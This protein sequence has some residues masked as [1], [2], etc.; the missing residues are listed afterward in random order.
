VTSSVDAPLVLDSSNAPHYRW[1]ADC[2]G[3]RLLDEPGLSVIE[4][5]VPPGAAEQRHHHATSRQFFYVLDGVATLSDRLDQ[6]AA[7]IAEGQS[8]QELGNALMAELEALHRSFS[9]RQQVILS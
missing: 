7:V 1:G 4:E 3:W 6:I 5:Q 9:E 2:D 8:I